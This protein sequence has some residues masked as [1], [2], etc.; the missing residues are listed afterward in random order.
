DL[1]ELVEYQCR[2]LGRQAG[3]GFIEDE[4]G[5]PRDESAGD[6]HHLPLSAGEPAGLKP[7]LAREIGEQAVYGGKLRG[8]V[9]PRQDIGGQREIV[10]DRHAR[11]DIFRLRNETQATAYQ[12]M[13]LALRD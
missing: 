13:R 10:F 4:N 9:G 2:K 7:A 1:R 5:R 6:R 12:L 3:R 11:E 8:P